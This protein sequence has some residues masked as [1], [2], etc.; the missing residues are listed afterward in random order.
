[1]HGCFQVA[2]KSAHVQTA[3]VQFDFCTLF[4][5][6][7]CPGQSAFTGPDNGET[8]T[9][10]VTYPH[11]FA[12]VP[13]ISV[14]PVVIDTFISYDGALRYSIGVASGVTTTGFT[15]SVTTWFGK[16]A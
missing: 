4:G 16:C 9:V 2:S 10:D 5:G 14:S 11:A 8:I 6:N 7:A 13:N 3:V 12:V 15:L 1:M